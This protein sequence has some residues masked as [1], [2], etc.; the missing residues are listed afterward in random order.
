LLRQAW[1][2]YSLCVKSAAESLAPPADDMAD[3][4]R[5]ACGDTP[6][7]PLCKLSPKTASYRY[8]A[9][10]AGTDMGSIASAGSESGARA[11]GNAHSHPVIS[12]KN[13]A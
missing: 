2:L 1:A 3:G 8:R 9:F 5:L 13:R 12:A 6:P 10:F 4:M 7:F 11:F